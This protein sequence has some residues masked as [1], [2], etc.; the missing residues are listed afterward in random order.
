LE[1][2]LKSGKLHKKHTSTFVETTTNDSKI[3]VNVDK[4][5]NDFNNTDEGYAPVLSEEFS[6]IEEL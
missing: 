4:F 2:H 5:D 6:G 1:E 3:V